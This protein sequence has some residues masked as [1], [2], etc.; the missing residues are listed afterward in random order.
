[1]KPHI[2]CFD[3]DGT[4][5]KSDS[6]EVTKDTCQALRNARENG[7]YIFINTGRSFAELDQ[8]IKEI[9]FDGV[10]CGCGT[11]IEYRGKN[12][13]KEEIAGELAQQIIALI[14][15]C[16]LQAVLEGEDYFYLS[17]YAT[18]EKMLK[19]KEYFGPEVN[20]RCRYWEEQ[21][22]K[23]QKMSVWIPDEGNF[24]E[25]QNRLEG[26]FDFIRRSAHFY[27]VV[28]K[29]YSKATGIE[30]LMKHLNIQQECTMAIGDSANDLSMLE[31]AKKS[32][33]MGN[34]SKDV[35]DKVSFVTKSVEEEG[36]AHALLHYGF[37]S[38]F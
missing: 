12:I 22:P 6:R 15:E 4:L 19:V 29:G 2:L 16:K 21:K 13:L 10:I 18:N 28:P 3:I 37:I 36:V 24:E 23:F 38:D 35:K 26:R 31:F 7:H 30:Y 8:E 11:Y 9:G 27:E 17:K 14:E 33:A 25:F 20:K 32:V 34:S 5:R 1:M